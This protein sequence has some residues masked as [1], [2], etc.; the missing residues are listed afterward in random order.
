MS[1]LTSRLRGVEGF[2]D[3]FPGAPSA[4]GDN[5]ARGVPRGRRRYRP[6]SP[7]GDNGGPSANWDNGTFGLPHQPPLPN[8]DN[9]RDQ[10]GRF[11]KGN[12][13]GPGNPFARRIAAFR[14]AL[15]QAIT[16]EDIQALARALLDKAK[17]GDLAAAKLLWLYTIGKPSDSVDP[18]TL[19]MHE[20]Q[21]F[22]QSPTDGTQLQA[23]LSSLPI[24]LACEILRA[25]MPA[26]K[27]AKEAKLGRR[28]DRQEQRRQRR[29]QDAERSGDPAAGQPP[30]GTS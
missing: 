24:Q 17:R 6:P 4:N 5:G 20:W 28:L 16:D 29:S 2:N 12:A 3:F 13:G 22:R 30:D 21:I 26:L 15:C 25:A 10:K 7:N 23:V 27:Q 18:D 1:S 19:D 8:G 14:T 9:G 11:A